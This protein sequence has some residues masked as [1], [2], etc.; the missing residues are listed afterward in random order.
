MQISSI[1]SK[2]INTTLWGLVEK[3][4]TTF[5]NFVVTIILA[6]LLLPSDYGIIAMMG[7]FIAIAN[8]FI[9]CGF[10][11]ALIR[12]LDTSQEDYSTAFYYNIGISFLV[13]LILFLTAPLFAAFYNLCE[14]TLIL[15][16]F[17]ITLIINSFGIVQHAILTKQLKFKQIAII[18]IV[19][20]LFSGIIGIGCAY[21]GLGVW[22]LIIQTLTSS[23]LSL[24]LLSFFTK[25]KPS[26][27][28]SKK[29]IS[30][31]W[32]FGNK[33]LVT[34]LISSTY[35]HLYSLLIG[36][37]YD[38]KTLGIFN[39]GQET[40]LIIP[41]IISSIF[42]KNSLPI[43]AELQNNREKLIETY[44]KFVLIVS[45]ITFPAVCLLFFLAEPF[46]MIVL[47]EKWA[48]SIMI[49]QIIAITTLFAPAS[50]I[51]LNLLQALGKPDYTLRAEII[52]K[53][54]GII[55]VFA[56]LNFGIEA[57]A[58]GSGCINLLAYGVNL[59]YAKKA[60]CLSFFVQIKDLTPIIL[61]TSVMAIACYATQLVTDNYYVY[62]ILCVLTGMATYY[63]TTKYIFKMNYYDHLHSLIKSNKNEIQ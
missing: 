24:I 18:S 53:I 4:A 3:I 44:R 37:A 62:T 29:S 45:F 20:G 30:Y 55:T 7:I 46:V 48:G 63:I 22:A 42:M 19:A 21:A 40:A 56:L 17:G 32:G 47:S 8:T 43:M 50:G 33:M 5:T 51:N 31:L 9:E 58:I 49:I 28:F 6:R 39:K 52:K 41:N 27:I 60:V 54:I 57:L 15:R 16:C 61:S 14:F 26:L 11:N 1:K 34:G 12:K 35:G 59:Y 10:C 25:W 38:S 23:T 13:Y 36:K 2:T